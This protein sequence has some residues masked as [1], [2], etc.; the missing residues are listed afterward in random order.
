MSEFRGFRCNGCHKIIEDPTERVKERVTL[1][2]ADGAEDESFFRDL[3]GDC[4]P[5]RREEI[6]QH[7]YEPVPKRRRRRSGQMVAAAS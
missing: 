4:A 5:E 2:Y 1:I 3:C 6:H 7:D